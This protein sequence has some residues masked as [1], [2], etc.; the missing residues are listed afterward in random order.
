MD[1]VPN[2]NSLSQERNMGTWGKC[3]LSFKVLR[4]TPNA[5]ITLYVNAAIYIYG[6]G[7]MSK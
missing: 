2:E 6:H 7:E 1:D 5:A 3:P 4:D